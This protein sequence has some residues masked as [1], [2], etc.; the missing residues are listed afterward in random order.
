MRPLS[1]HIVPESHDG[2]EVRPGFHTDQHAGARGN[3]PLGFHL[4]R[5]R[6]RSYIDTGVFRENRVNRVTAGVIKLDL[7]FVYSRPRLRKLGAR[8]T[9]N[10][11]A[12]VRLICIHQRFDFLAVIKVCVAS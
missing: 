1:L 3:L 4:L 7:R 9:V 10:R 11:T 6:H 12:A 2:G 8:N 5:V